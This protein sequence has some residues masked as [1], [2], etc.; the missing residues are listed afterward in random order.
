MV[1]KL[2]AKFWSLGQEPPKDKA[3]Y[4][5][6]LPQVAF[7]PS[8]GI[9]RF[10]HQ[11]YHK[12]VLPN[13]IE[14]N[15]AHIKQLNPDYEYKLWDDNDIDEFILSQYGKE[16]F[17][18]YK[19]I[20]PVY[21][22]ARADLFRYLLIYR[23]GGIYI[24]IKST[25]TKP[26]INVINSNDNCIL[27]HWDNLPGQAH[28]G[29]SAN[30]KELNGYPRGEFVQWQLIY[31]A[32]HPLLREIIVEVLHRIEH[33]NPFVRS[34]GRGGVL[35]TTGPIPYSEVILSALNKYRDIIDIRELPDMGLVYSIY[36]TK[37]DPNV[38]KKVMPSNYWR[39]TMPVVPSPNPIVQGVSRL[40]LR[41]W[42]TILDLKWK[43]S[44]KEGQRT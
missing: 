27:C 30:H 3:Y 17:E 42:Y 6:L 19:K 2:F 28:E 44:G 13:E 15:I 11:T 10:I 41:I 35:S 29:W 39:L 5:A 34:I 4:E 14:N 32:G 18:I 38:H 26:L 7:N 22:A 33:Y 25:L 16:V 23:M 40:F 21:G 37:E 12:K 1:K 20:V 36:E 9:E 8:G 43:L 24:D 31:K